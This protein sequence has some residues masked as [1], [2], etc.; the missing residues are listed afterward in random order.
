M[1]APFRYMLWLIIMVLGLA[2][3]QPA[4]TPT[5]PA[6]TEAPPV[7]APTPMDPQ[8]A[9]IPGDATPDPLL[10]RPYTEDDPLTD[11]EEILHILDELQ[12]R[13]V[14][15]FSRPGWYRFTREWPSGRDY[16]RKQYVLTHVLNENRDC[17]EQFSY[18]EQDG[19]ILPHLIH[20][21]DGSFGL[22]TQTEEGTFHLSSVL[23]P[24]E[25]PQCDLGNGASIALGADDGDFILHN[26]AFQFQRYSSSVIEGIYK[27]FWAWVEEFNG[28]QTLVLVYDNIIEDPTLRGAILNPATGLFVPTARNQRFHYIDLETGLQVRFDEDHYLEDG[29]LVNSDD[30]GL[31]YSYEYLEAMPEVIRESY[32]VVAEEVQTMLDE[33]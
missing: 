3:C 2:S 4:A 22:L 17:L 21:A 14:A 30:V 26:E 32:E 7:Q 23:P 1:K 5:L 25:V 18:F 6:P 24:E 16:T 20:P 8:S 11:P 31:L 27:D 15:W 12:R 33:D 19:L 28:K 9:V 10:D 29:T 13:E